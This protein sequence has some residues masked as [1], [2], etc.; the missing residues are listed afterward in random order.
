MLIDMANK[1]Y[2]DY[3]PETETV[4]VNPRLKRAHPR[5]RRQASTT[6]CSSSTATMD[7]GVNATL[8]LLNYDLALQGVSRILMSDSAGRDA[9]IPSERSW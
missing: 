4:H 8:N 9:S 7:D 2:L 5:Q 1:G 3:D 6:T